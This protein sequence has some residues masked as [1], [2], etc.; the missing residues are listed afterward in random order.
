[1]Q[2]IYEIHFHLYDLLA[3][4]VSLFSPLV[5]SYLPTPGYLLFALIIASVNELLSFGHF[6]T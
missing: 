2:D 5:I 6:G 3:P 4:K 1:M